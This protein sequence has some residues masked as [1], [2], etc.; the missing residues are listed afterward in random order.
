[1]E[2][3]SNTNVK[4]NDLPLGFDAYCQA[5]EILRKI[6]LESRNIKHFIPEFDG[7][8]MLENL[9]PIDKA[10]EEGKES[11]L[12]QITNETYKIVKK[13]LFSEKVRGFWEGGIIGEP[14]KKP[15][16]SFYESKIDRY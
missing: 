12:Y 6:K 10:L 15:D 5:S 16:L 9:L 13:S 2:E 4:E 11:K 14:I 3:K 1:M 8:K 7:I